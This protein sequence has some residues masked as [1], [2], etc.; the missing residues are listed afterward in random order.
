MTI[1]HLGI[2]G[3]SETLLRLEKRL[4]EVFGEPYCE[5]VFI[6]TYR[7][8]PIHESYYDTIIGVLKEFDGEFEV[9]ELVDVKI[10]EDGSEELVFRNVDKSQLFTE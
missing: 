9:K 4:S 6:Q 8:L 10:N 1:R 7:Y 2:F 3:N 5:S